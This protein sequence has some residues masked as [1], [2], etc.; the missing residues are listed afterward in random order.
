MVPLPPPAPGP[1]ALRTPAPGTRPG[2]GSPLPGRRLVRGERHAGAS[3]RPRPGG[4]RLRP[5]GS[6]D[7]GTPA[8]RLGQRPCR[9]GTALDEVARGYHV[10]R[11][12]RG[13]RGA[14]LTDV[15]APRPARRGRALGGCRRTCVVGGG[16]FRREPAGGRPP[17]PPRHLLPH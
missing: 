15:R 9:D 12:L 10:S 2:P 11:A 4:R 1:A 5:G 8:A 13:D 16:P 3:D 7:P 14:R 6:A 17:P